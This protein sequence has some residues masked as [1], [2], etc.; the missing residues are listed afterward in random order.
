MLKD[1]LA[2]LH[3]VARYSNILIC[4]TDLGKINLRIVE[5]F[6]CLP[7][8]KLLFRWKLRTVTWHFK[9]QMNYGETKN[10]GFTSKIFPKENEF[11]F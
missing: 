8:G 2:I 11:L 10:G 5:G 6:L 4:D 1:E 7:E 9:A 3:K